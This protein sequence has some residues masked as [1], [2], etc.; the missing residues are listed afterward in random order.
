M[1][2][3]IVSLSHKNSDVCLREKFT[4]T[5]DQKE[6]C[7]Q[8]LLQCDVI[9]EAFILA[10]CN[11][12][13]LYGCCSD[14][15]G[16]LEHMLYLLTSKSGL[17]K[18]FIKETAEI[19][20]DSSAIHH[21][22]AVASSIDSMVVGETQI[23]G[24]LKDAFRFAQSKGYCEEKMSRAVEHAFK[25]AAKVRNFTEI[26]SKPV[27]V[28]SVAISQVKEKV[29]NLSDKKALVIGVGEMSEICA[30]HL[31]SDGVET[32]VTNRTKEKAQHLATSCGAKVYEFGDLHKAVNQFD[33]IFT[34]TS[35]Q[36]PII[37]NDL[38]EDVV[39]E[40]FWFDLAIPRDIEMTH[41][42]NIYLF[43]IDDI[44]N[45]VSENKA[46]REQD[47]RKAHG[48]VGRSVVAFYEWLDTLNVEPMIKEIYLKAQSAV[49]EEMAR[50]LK[51]GFIPKECENEAKKMANQ[52]IKRFLHDMTKNMRE[53]STEAKSDSMTGAMQYMLNSKNDNIPDKYKHLI[54]K[55]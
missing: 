43:S 22:F 12:V 47:V 5:D 37:T 20:D 11:R 53:I 36:Y 46:Q 18:E 8:N 28:A 21:L 4:Y 17:S 39:Y 50:A 26:S 2:Y 1:H 42:E 3:L 10:T 24:Q 48:I 52:A 45:V 32:Y 38:I 35:A 7:L 15:D 41:K 31:I 51:K 34:A 33:I 19:V 30:K 25:T 13:E 9:S 49:E 44:K 27:S 23:A 55:D 14:I 16:A 54:K 29:S 6:T 40:R